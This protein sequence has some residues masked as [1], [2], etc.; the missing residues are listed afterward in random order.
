MTVTALPD[1]HFRFSR[2]S[3]DVSGVKNPIKII[4]DSDKSIT[5]NFLRIIYPPLD[6]SGQRVLNRSLSQAEYIDVLTWQANP[7]NVNIVKYRIYQVDKESQDLLVELNAGTFQY[8]NRRAEKDKQY[9]YVL[10][11]VDDEGR[12]GDSSQITVQ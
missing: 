2:W 11:A 8:W 9:T 4:M 5:A 1:D 3:G 6:F 7:D 10:C 12:E